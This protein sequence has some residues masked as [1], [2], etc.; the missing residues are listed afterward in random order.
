MARAIFL[1]PADMAASLILF[2]AFPW[3]SHRRYEVTGF[4]TTYPHLMMVVV[5]LMGYLHGAVNR[6]RCDRLTGV[7]VSAINVAVV[8]AETRLPRG[9]ARC[10]SLSHPDMSS[11]SSDVKH[12]R[13]KRFYMMSPNNYSLRV[14]RPVCGRGA[15]G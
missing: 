4:R 14:T 11:R 1:L 3:L 5:G 15:I 7:E 9:A 8:P 6:K 13:K 12:Y 2:A 10:P